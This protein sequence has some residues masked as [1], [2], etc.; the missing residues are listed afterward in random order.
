MIADTAYDADWSLALLA[1]LDSVAVI[2]P[3]VNRTAQRD[4][5]RHLYK[6]RH[7][8]ECFINKLK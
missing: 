5:D 2:L 6:E 8:V 7:L 3:R 1:E 4:C